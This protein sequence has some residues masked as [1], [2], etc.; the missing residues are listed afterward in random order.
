MWVS[1]HSAGYQGSNAS[2]APAYETSIDCV[3]HVDRHG[4]PPNSESNMVAV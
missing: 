2:R 1:P 3:E 4:G